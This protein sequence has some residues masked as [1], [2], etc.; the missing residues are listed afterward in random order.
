[1]QQIIIALTRSFTSLMRPDI[2]KYVI[3]PPV[4]G[5]IIWVIASFMWLITLTDWLVAETPLSTLH[6]WLNDW[7]LAWF[8]TGVAF[9]GAW[10]VLLAG[11]YLIAIMIAGVWALP[12]IVHILSTTEYTDVARHGNDSLMVSIGVTGKA[13]LLYTIGWILTLPVWIVPGMSVVHS[14]FWLAYLNRATFA[15]DALCAHVTPEEWQHI[16][17]THAKQLWLLGLLSAL[18]AHIPVVGFFAPVLAAMAFAHYGLQEL[19]AI[20][21]TSDGDIGGTISGEFRRIES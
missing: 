20:R 9:L 2:W 12:G 16:K 14:F 6:G 17:S 7:S 10:V 1:M 11:A 3:L 15:F 18:L 19:R 4:I 13:V 21:S 5:T 8:A